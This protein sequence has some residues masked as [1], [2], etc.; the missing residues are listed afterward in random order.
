MKCPL[1]N[2]TVGVIN[3]RNSVSSNRR[4]YQCANGHR[5]S[6]IEE[7]DL[8]TLDSLSQYDDDENLAKNISQTPNQS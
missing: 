6:T 4:R 8:H 5:F 3:V 2:E 7:I 1:C